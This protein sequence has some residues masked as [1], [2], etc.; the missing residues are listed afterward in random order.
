MKIFG[1]LIVNAPENTLRNMKSNSKAYMFTSTFVLSKKLLCIP[2]DTEIFY[3]IEVLKEVRTSFFDTYVTVYKKGNWLEE[4]SFNLDFLED[5]EL[6][7]VEWS[8]IPNSLAKIY[9]KDSD[10]ICFSGV[11]IHYI[12]K[13]RKELNKEKLLSKQSSK[14][15]QILLNRAEEEEDYEK[16]VDIRDEIESRKKMD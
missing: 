3:S 14:E 8:L 7:G 1:E 5:I 13:Y 10:W 11:S 15:L 9:E 6:S 2:L 16:A 4:E 12:K